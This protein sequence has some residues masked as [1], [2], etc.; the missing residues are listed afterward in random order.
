[1]G[2][3]GLPENSW[4]KGGKRLPRTTCTVRLLP[5]MT[6]SCYMVSLVRVKVLD[7]LRRYC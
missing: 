2:D 3:L 4:E 6:E 5:L 1:M 7:S